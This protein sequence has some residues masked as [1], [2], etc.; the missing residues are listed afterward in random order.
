MPDRTR[1]R[2]LAAAC[3]LGVCAFATASV[4]V[5]SDDNVQQAENT[6]VVLYEQGADATQAR[7][8]VEAAGGRVARENAAVGVAEV[9]SA[10]AEFIADVIGRAGVQ[11]AATQ[12][13]IGRAPGGHPKRDPAEQRGRGGKPGGRP[14]GHHGG[15]RPPSAEPLAPRQWDMKM[16]GADAEGSY[17]VQQGDRKVKVGIIDTG[18]DGTHPDIAPNFNAELSRNFTTDDPLVDGPCAEEPDGSCEDPANV[19]ENEHG[20]HVAGTIAAPLNG[21]GM[22]GVAPK[23]EIVNLRAGQDSGYFFLQPTV[24][25]L[26][27]AGDNGIDVVNMSYYIDPWLFNCTANPADSPEQQAE[28]RTVIEATQRALRYAR[29]RGVTLVGAA[30]NQFMDLGKPS[31]DAT[32]PDYPPGAEK[33]RTID[34]SC[35]TLPAE[36]EGTIAVTSVGPSG[37]KAYYSSYGIEQ[38]DVAAPGGDVR[39]SATPDQRVAESGIL[40][41]YPESLARQDP[42]VNPDGTPNDPFVVRDCAKGRCAYYQYLQGTSMA[43]PHAAGVAALIVAQYGR[44]DRGGITLDPR[45]TERVLKGTATDTACPE[46]R[47]LDYPDPLGPEYTATCEGDASRNGFY[48]EG[49]VNALRAVTLGR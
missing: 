17:R 35:I 46:P 38:A 4:T 7:E 37:R 8:A 10:N 21:L 43:S 34:N 33:P 18:V 31:E 24:D 41:P 47:T 32:S 25:A 22:A 14:G 20:T 28:Q 44:K 30:G 1:R 2:L 29:D 36:G 27:Y 11:G 13:A 19:D 45:V 23:A 26:T 9:R 49:V 42:R 48:G 15:G 6:Y 16:I 5:A 12:R 40:A 3:T 39:D